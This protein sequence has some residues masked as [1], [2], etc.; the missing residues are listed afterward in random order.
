MKNYKKIIL[1][2]LL[3]IILA[4]TAYLI[5]STYAKYLSSATGDATIAI[6]RWNITVN[7]VSIKDN[8]DLSSKI[9]PVFPG[10]DNIAANIIAP[11]AEG[12]FDIEFDCT[13]VDVSFKYEINVSADETSAVSDIVATGYS[14]DGGEKIEFEQYNEAITGT[15]HLTDNVTSKTFRIYVMWDDNPDTTTMNNIADTESTLQTNSSAVFNVTVAFTQ[16][17]E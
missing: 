7:Q 14:V 17:T 11:T 3:C 8:P 10:N 6:S 15:I 12:Y 4:L 13:D 1:I 9:V 5:G 16:I 2:I